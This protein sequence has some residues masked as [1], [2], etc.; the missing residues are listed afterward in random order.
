MYNF[1]FG[2]IKDVIAFIFFFFIAIVIYNKKL[3]FFQ[4]SIMCIIAGI[5]DCVFTFNPHLHNKIIVKYNV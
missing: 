1:T 4:L 3:S 5:I 2:Y